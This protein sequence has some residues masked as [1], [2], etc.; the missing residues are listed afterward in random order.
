[1][2]KFHKEHTFIFVQGVATL[3]F[4]IYVCSKKAH[5][6]LKNATLNATLQFFKKEPLKSSGKGGKARKC[7]ILLM[8]K[9]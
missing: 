8:E 7:P 1:L 6:A 4:S 3:V 2:C 5:D 9:Q